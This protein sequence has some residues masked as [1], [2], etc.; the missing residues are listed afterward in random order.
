MSLYIGFILSLLIILETNAQ[1]RIT[2]DP[3]VV[4]QQNFEGWGTSIC[5]WGELEGNGSAEY[6]KKIADVLIDPDSGLGFN[7]FRYNIGGGDQSGHNHMRPGGAIPGYKPSQ[8]EPYDWNADQN[9]RAMALSIAERAKVKNISLIWEAFSNF[10]PWWMTI[11]G[12]S[13][14]NV[15]CADNLKPEFFDDFADYLTDVVKHFRD[16]RG[17]N[18]RTVETFNE[19]SASWWKEGN[20]QEGCGFNSKQPL[21]VKLLGRTLISKGLFPS[22]KVSAADENSVDQAVNGLSVYDDSAFSF[23]SQINTHTYYGRT[24]ANFSKLYNIAKNRK[25]LLWQSETGPLAGKGNQ[26]IAMFMSQ[27]II[28]DLRMLKPNAWLD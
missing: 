17:I 9:Q 10:P 14:G 8:A 28:E 2:V 16:F 7:I 11:S 6:R 24:P 18:F 23:M 20:N 12:C 4:Y 15:N 22:T 19:P 21:M 1:I 26:D 5:W 3:E 27:Y 25:K 13:A